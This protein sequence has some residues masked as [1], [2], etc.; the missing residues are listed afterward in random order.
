M[1]EESRGFSRAAVRRVGF[2]LSYDGELRE[3]LVWPQLSPVSIRVERGS[4]ALLSNNGSGIRCQ[5]ALKGES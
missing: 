2:L 5:D 1:T 3:P 4:A